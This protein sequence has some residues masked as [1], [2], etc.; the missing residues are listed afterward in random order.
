MDPTPEQVAAAHA[1]YTRRS[2]AVYDLAILG[3]FS[4][5]AWRCPAARVLA[6][7][8]R[9]VSANHLDV[10][11]GTGYFLDRCAFP[12]PPDRPRLGLLDLST[13]CLE[14]ASK[15]VARFGPEVIEA[16]V[17]EPISYHGPRFDSVGLNYLLHCLPGDMGSKAVALDHLIAL[18]NPGATVFGATLLHDGVPRNWFA[19]KL[20]ARNNAHGIFSNASD[21]LDSLRSAISERLSGSSIEVIGCVGLFAGTV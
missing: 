15:R 3:Y 8:D 16:N 21:S 9:H 17:L 6:H 5:L 20:M 1:F 7:Y 19:R 2:L 13:T 12:S 14:V 4:R 10:G 11:V 18:A